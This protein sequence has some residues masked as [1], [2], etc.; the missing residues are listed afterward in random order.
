[1]AQALAGELKG[2]G[3]DLILF[4]KM[5]IDDYNH[6]VGPWWPSCSTCHA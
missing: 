3:F 1:V 2:A 6:Q 4:G 5:A